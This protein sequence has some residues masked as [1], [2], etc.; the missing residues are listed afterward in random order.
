[1]TDE[2]GDIGSHVRE[3]CHV[4]RLHFGVHGLCGVDVVLDGCNLAQ[5]RSLAG[6]DHIL[7][8]V[9]ALHGRSRSVRL[10]HFALGIRERQRPRAQWRWRE[11]PSNMGN[12]GE[13]IHSQPRNQPASP[14]AARD[15]LQSA[16]APDPLLVASLPHLASAQTG[17]SRHSHRRRCSSVSISSVVLVAVR[18]LDLLGSSGLG[19]GLSSS[20]IGGRRDGGG[21]GGGRSCC[22]HK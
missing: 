18:R 7:V 12:I 16:F 21:R 6:L 13:R 5:R 10:R 4:Q 17:S 9:A 14:S 1:M 3:A 20:R 8:H 11:R 15:P 19:L 22:A 2:F